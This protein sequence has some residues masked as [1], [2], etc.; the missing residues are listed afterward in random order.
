MPDASQNRPT[1]GTYTTTI[2]GSVESSQIA[3]GTAITQTMTL[4]P[5]EVIG[6]AGVAQ[7]RQALAELRRQ[8]AADAP[9]EKQAE[10]NQL[11]DEFEAAVTDGAPDLS[12]MEYV[13]NWFARNLPKIAGTVTEIIVHPLVGRL[14]EAAGDVLVGEFRQRF[15]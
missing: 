6:E 15:G 13:R 8:V 14:V 2:G 5:A 3:T 10:A 4:V 11:V 1:G 7:L 9:E 12:T